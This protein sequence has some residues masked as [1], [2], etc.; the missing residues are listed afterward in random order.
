MKK[1]MKRVL[2]VLLYIILILTI[3]F[4]VV[5]NY[6]SSTTN[7]ECTGSFSNENVK[8]DKV[9]LALEEYS[10]IVDLYKSRN[11]DGNLKAEIPGKTKEY[12]GTI[13]DIGNMYQI[14]KYDNKF[15]GQFSTLSNYLSLNIPTYGVFDGKCNKL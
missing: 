3:S 4:I 6:G 9:F 12:Y 14:H 7:Y 13:E 10:W 8:S 15:Q 2:K 11:T 1:S 5:A